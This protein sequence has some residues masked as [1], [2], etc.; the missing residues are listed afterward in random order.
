MKEL[1]EDKDGERKAE[2][3]LLSGPNEF[4]E[5]YS[6]LKGIKEFHKKHPDEIS[7][8]L[9]TE[10][11]QMAK[12]YQNSEAMSLLVEFTDEE[13][14]GRYL[15]L[16][17]CYDKYINI[18]GVEKTDYITY[19][20]IFDHLYD[21]PKDRKNS[22]Y[23]KYLE[24]LYT[25]LYGFNVKIKPLHDLDKDLDQTKLDFE[26]QWTEGVFPGWQKKEQESALSNTGAPLDLSAFTSWEELASLGLDRLKSALMAMGLKCGV[27]LE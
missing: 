17:E 7:I 25:Y 22:E 13:G 8:P 21:I 27:T 18:R 12:A 23:K 20:M 11:E 2:I 9:S 24:V 5:F 16:H 1:Y 3:A 10:F 15:D 14:Y 4:S 6:R 26:R 19:L